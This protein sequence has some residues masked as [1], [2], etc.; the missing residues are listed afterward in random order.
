MFKDYTEEQ[1]KNIGFGPISIKAIK[2]TS[3]SNAV[4]GL[5]DKEKQFIQQYNKAASSRKPEDRAFLTSENVKRY[6]DLIKK[7]R[8]Y[9]KANKQSKR[10]QKMNQSIAAAKEDNA[11]YG[12]IGTFGE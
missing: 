5:T 4:N 7:Q 1:L 10:D 9:N 2:G 6:S 8:E 3:N 12:D 11:V